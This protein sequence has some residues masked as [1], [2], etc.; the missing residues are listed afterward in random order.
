MEEDDDGALCACGKL[1]LRPFV[2]N[3]LYHELREE[4]GRESCQN[5]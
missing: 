2:V 1:E 4:H 3:V 5:I